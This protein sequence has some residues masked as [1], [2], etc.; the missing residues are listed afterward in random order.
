MTD[1]RPRWLDRLHMGTRGNLTVEFAFIAPL[2]ILFSF[3]ALELGHVLLERLRMATAAEAALQ[4]AL[5]DHATAYDRAGIIAAAKN[6]AGPRSSGYRVEPRP[7]CTCAA[8]TEVSCSAS[9]A[10]AS[11]PRTYIEVSVSGAVAPLVSYPFP[12]STG[13]EISSHQARRLN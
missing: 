13:W 9:C 10:D 11:D 7:Y 2:L 8:A 12:F 1:P 3:A 5:Q 4:Y 6:S